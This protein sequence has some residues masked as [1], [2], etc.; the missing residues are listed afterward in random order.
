MIYFISDDAPKGNYHEMK[1]NGTMPQVSATACFQS[2]VFNFNTWLLFMQYGCCFGVELTMNNAAALYF[3]EEFNQTTESAAAIASIFGWMNL[4]ARGLGGLCSDRSNAK[5]GMRGRLI[6]QLVLLIL[7]GATVLVFA[8]TKSLGASI[9]VMVVFS[10]FVQAAEGSTYGI[11][12][13]I[14]PPATG[15]IA[16][17]VGAGG[18]TFAVGFGIAFRQMEYDDAFIIMAGAIFASSL[19]TPFI[20]IRNHS[21]L[22]FGVDRNGEDD[23]AFDAG[24]WT[25]HLP[26]KNIRAK[27]KEGSDEEDVPVQS[28]EDNLPSQ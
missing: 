10:I 6:T 16:G 20:C 14:E 25:L 27:R 4:F 28:V 15:S 11:V 21:S 22:F 18:S 5:W 8:N 7:E 1:K 12:P 9:V 26:F 3:K 24:R 23:A 19:L 2:G 17:I 13:Y